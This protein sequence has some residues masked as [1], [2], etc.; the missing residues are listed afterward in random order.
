MLSSTVNKLTLGPYFLQVFLSLSIYILVLA[1]RF[2]VNGLS[3]N[4]EIS[5]QA[6]ENNAIQYSNLLP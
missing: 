2:R 3:L 4:S 5:M 6:D 1:V